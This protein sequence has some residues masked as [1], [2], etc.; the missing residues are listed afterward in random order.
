MTP[1]SGGIAALELIALAIA[2]YLAVFYLRLGYFLVFVIPAGVVLALLVTRSQRRQW[3]ARAG[4]VLVAVAYLVLQVLV[5]AGATTESKETHTMRWSDGDGGE[6]VLEFQ[7]FPGNHIGV[8]ADELRKH[9]DAAGSPTVE[10]ELAVTRDIGCLR[11]FHV[12]R[13]GD[14]ASWDP[15]SVGYTGAIGD[16]T[17][18][19]S[20]PWW[21]P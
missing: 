13:V 3:P 4:P 2:I 14:F 12:A 15:G 6:V 19:W 9:L 16:T 1:R 7:G 11:G 8:H 10:V 20:D 18:P 21:C 17:S 5:F